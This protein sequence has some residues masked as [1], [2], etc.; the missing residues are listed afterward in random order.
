MRCAA[1]ALCC[2]VSCAAASADTRYLPWGDP[3]LQGTW[4]NATITGLER[5]DSFDELVLTQDQARR[6]EAVDAGHTAAIDAL[7][8]GDL[9]SGVMVGGYNSAWLD[10]GTRVLRVDGEPRSSIIT[11]PADGKVPYTFRGWAKLW[12]GL[13]NSQK[14]NNP[15][16]MLNGDRCTVGYGSTGGPPMLPVLYNNNYRIVQT[17]GK[18]SILVEMNH[19]VR[20]IR[21]DGEPLPAAIR[22]WLGDSIGHWEGDTLVVRTTQF[23]PQQSLRGAIKHQLYMGAD[24]VVTERFTRIRD[25]QIRYHFTVED[26]DVYSQPW[27]GELVFTP[28]SGA[29][30]E[31]ACHEG[32]YGMVNMLTAERRTGTNGLWWLIGLA[33]NMPEEVS[34]PQ[35][36][37]K[38]FD[39]L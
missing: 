30:Y 8:E 12:W 27:Q 7:P 23:H 33:L 3:D 6:I 25:D 26:D 16:E 22:P 37:A 1:F 11:S 18:V 9:P 19:A 32:N 34:H 2:A 4:T 14:H 39:D 20:T 13:I 31:Y 10:R 5:W 21:I 15:E 38:R 35:L 28:S 17:P 36:S 24:S 29:I